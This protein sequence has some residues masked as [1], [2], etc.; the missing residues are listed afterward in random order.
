MNKQDKYKS[1]N[2]SKINS[3]KL[4]QEIFYFI[5]NPS[6]KPTRWQVQK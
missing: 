1:P 6:M 4:E 3:N 2:I 5:P